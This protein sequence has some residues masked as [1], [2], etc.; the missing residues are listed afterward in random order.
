MAHQAQK[1]YCEEIK[2]RFPYFFKDSKILDCGS[3]D[4]NGSNRY[5]FN[6]CDYTGIDI[7]P[8]KNVDIVSTIHEFSGEYNIYDTIIS[9]ECFEHDIFYKKSIH[10]IIRMLKPSGLFIFTCATTGRP[11]HGTKTRNPHKAPHLHKVDVDGWSDY[12]KNLTAEDIKE[13][14]LE[15]YSSMEEIFEEFEFDSIQTPSCDLRF[16]GIKK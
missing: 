6:N 2:N 9:T 11:V 4:I 10:N 7:G 3:L 12:Y 14:I 8:G 1:E 13:A 5:L 15:K 16:W